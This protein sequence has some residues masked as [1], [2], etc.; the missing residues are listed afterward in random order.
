MGMPGGDL[1]TSYFLPRLIGMSRAAEYLYTS[2]F[3]DA[4]TAAAIGFVSRVVPDYEL[5]AA[6]ASLVREF[7]NVTPFALRMTKQILNAN[8]DAAGL[9]NALKLEQRSQLLCGLTEDMIECVRANIFEKR[10]PEYKDR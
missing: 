9:E 7:L 2:R 4:D 8:V 6:I 10:M 1:G 3:F 5:E